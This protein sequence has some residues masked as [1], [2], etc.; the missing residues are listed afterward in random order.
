MK[1]YLNKI[2]VILLLVATWSCETTELDLVTNPNSPSPDNLDVDFTLNRI[3]LDFAEFFEQATEAGGA[4]TRLEYMFDEYDVN[5]NN[6][7]AN[8]TVMWRTAYADLLKD[9]ETLIPIATDSEFYIHSAIART[10]KAYTLMTMV[11]Y[12]KDVPYSEA[13]IATNTDTDT[14]FPSV[15]PGSEVYAAALEELNTALVEFNNTSLGEP[16]N[17][18]YY[19]GSTDKW[20]TLINTLKF[21]YYLNLRLA[22]QAT[23]TAGIN[24]LLTEG[25]LIEASDDNFVFQFGTAEV[26]ASKHPYYIQEYDAANVGEYIPNYLMWSL[27]VEKGFEDPRLRYYVYRQSGEFP[28]DEATLNNVI[29]CWNDPRP[30]TYAAIDAILDTPLP[31]CAL[32]DRA[33][34]YWGRDHA[35]ADGI[36]PDNSLRSTFGLYPI[37]GNLDIDTFDEVGTG[38][39]INGAGIW[40]IMTRS[41]TYFMRAEAALYL[42]TGEDP[43]LMLEEGIRASM[44]DVFSLNSSYVI[45]RSAVVVVADD[46]DTAADETVLGGDFLPVDQDVEDYVEFVTNSFGAAAGTE[47]QMAIIGKEYWIA[48]Y[49]NG[50]EAYN[51][52]KRTGMPNTLQPTLLGTSTFPRSFLYPAESV[53]RNLNITQ[54]S[55]TDKS[56]WDTNPDGFIQ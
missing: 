10:L 4:A 28:T 36:P 55:L 43:Q 23:A 25:N 34:G 42:G 21:K 27:A 33:D 39:G 56:F 24:A 52:Y 50:V 8:I 22:D 30:A 49:G 20:I 37:G 9:I 54:K 7:N 29:D 48:L 47:Q 45:S 38:D 2:G 16:A 6:S 11:D 32:F 15:D 41:F 53:E 17:D 51:L 5:Y 31:F 1:N 12:F 18:L 13:L 46:E 3:Q 35:E 19:G 26:P 40:P 44:D 14:F